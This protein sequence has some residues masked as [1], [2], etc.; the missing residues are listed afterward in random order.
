MYVYCDIREIFVSL[1]VVFFIIVSLLESEVNG[2]AAD[3]GGGL[4]DAAV[5][6]VPSPR[7]FFG[8]TVPVPQVLLELVFTLEPDKDR[9][10]CTINRIVLKLV[11]VLN[12]D[13]PCRHCYLLCV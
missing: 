1:F 4:H 3:L 11:E 7:T 12:C 13:V 10:C 6:S 5:C 8:H 2:E 9:D